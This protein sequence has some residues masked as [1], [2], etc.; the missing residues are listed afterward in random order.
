MMKKRKVVAAAL[1]VFTS[2]ACVTAYA[3]HNTLGTYHWGA[4]PSNQYEFENWLGKEQQYI[5]DFVGD[6]TWN[7]ISEPYWLTSV[8][9]NTKYNHSVILS[10]PLLPQSPAGCSLEDGAAGRYNQYFVRLAE[11]LVQMGMEKTIIRPGWEMNGNWYRWAAGGKEQTYA[12]YFA[13]VVTA[14]RSVNGAEFQFL[15]NPAMGEQNA[16][17]LAC[18]PGNDYVDFVGLDVY[19]ES[20]APN[21]YP[22]PASASDSEAALRRTNAW[23]SALTRTYGLNW[24]TEFAAKNGK[25]IIIGEWGLDIRPDGHG[26]GDD[27]AFVTRMHDWLQAHDDLIFAHVYFDVTAPDGDHAIS[28]GEDTSFPAGAQEF[29]RLWGPEGSGMDIITPG[30]DGENASIT[31]LD[32]LVNS[33]ART[34]TIKG[35]LS[36]LQPSAGIT[37]KVLGLGAAAEQITVSDVIHAGETVSGADGSFLYKFQMKAGSLS[38]DETQKYP[39]ILDAS[40]YKTAVCYMNYADYSAVS[41]ALNDLKNSASANEVK[42]KLGRYANILINTPLYY[43]DGVITD[44]ALNAAAETL[45]NARGSAFADE[46]TF[47]KALKDALI[48]NALRYAGSFD[49]FLYIIEQYNET[50]GLDY[51]NK[52]YAGSIIGDKQNIFKK[53]YDVRN[54]LDSYETLRNVFLET[55]FSEAINQGKRADISAVIKDMGDFCIQRKPAARESINGYRSA[56]DTARAYIDME[57]YKAAPADFNKLLET[58]RLAYEGQK[59]QSSNTSGGS[60]GGSGGGGSSTH[61]QFVYGDE[62]AETGR[63]VIFSDLG[64]VQWAKERI[65][66]LAEKGIVSGYNG[67][68]NP[69]DCITRSEFVKLIVSAFGLYDADAVSSYADAQAHWSDKY[70]ASAAKYGIVKGFSETEFGCDYPITRE[71]MTVIIERTVKAFTDI[72]ADAGSPKTFGDSGS[73]SGYAAEAVAFVTATGIINGYEDNTFRPRNNATRAEAA[74]VIYSLIN[75]E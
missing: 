29:K 1:A 70:V 31:V 74:V 19:D 15:W 17:V 22:I 75:R 57:L 73:I 16:D 43:M 58:L 24:L 48:L 34:V 69:S 46:E 50:I 72:N 63:D 56:S 39:V 20:W 59:T 18:Y 40:G 65:L 51:S 47:N 44:R 6:E 33:A 5:L 42:T 26:G 64:S 35:R 36:D 12:A 9:K 71:D 28:N 41:A 11:H 62:P 8:W 45:Y 23:D 25:P 27:A 30:E 68:F 38:T 66:S 61:V 14:M 55:V 32:I 53:M 13:N 7:S 10:V 21:T 60:S 3:D 52:T 49:S 4:N 37:V 2:V 54:G 67:K